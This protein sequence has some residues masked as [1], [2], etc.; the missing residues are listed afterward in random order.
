MCSDTVMNML[1]RAIAAASRNS[2]RFFFSD[3]PLVLRQESNGQ[4]LGQIEITGVLRDTRQF[5]LGSLESC[6]VNQRLSTGG[7]ALF[8][9]EDGILYPVCGTTFKDNG[10]KND[11]NLL[12]VQVVALALRKLIRRGNGL[13]STECNHVLATLQMSNSLLH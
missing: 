1:E 7:C 2:S 13:I 8:P 4:E 9:Y 6:G 5:R 3:C 11:R 12:V 10:S